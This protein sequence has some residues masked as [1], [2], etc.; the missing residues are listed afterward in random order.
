MEWECQG[1]S[2]IV[3]YRVELD[4]GLSVLCHRDEHW[5]VRDLALQPEGP[6]MGADGTRDTKR[7][8]KRRAGDAWEYVDH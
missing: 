6:R 7:I 8:V 3:P 1:F 5:L 4:N 2:G